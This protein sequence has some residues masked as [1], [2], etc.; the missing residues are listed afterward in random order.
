ML[1]ILTS[2]VKKTTQL[3]L[4]MW[5][6]QKA[7]S[8]HWNYL[9]LLISA[10]MDAPVPFT[11]RLLYSIWKAS[12]KTLNHFPFLANAHAALQLK[13]TLDCIQLCTLGYERKTILH[14]ISSVVPLINTM[15]FDPSNHYFS[16]TPLKATR[17]LPTL[18]NRVTHLPKLLHGKDIPLESN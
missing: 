3:A 4:R 1:C 15:G 9:S 10:D 8:R 18:G 17:T 14:P 7:R 16:E 11:Y 12:R 6:S 13:S 5:N 2:I